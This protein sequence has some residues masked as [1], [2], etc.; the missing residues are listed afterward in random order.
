MAQALTTDN[1]NKIIKGNFDGIRTQINDVKV[2]LKV[3]RE[4]VKKVSWEVE[5]LRRRVETLE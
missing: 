4:E 1:I 2:E 5:G 3:L